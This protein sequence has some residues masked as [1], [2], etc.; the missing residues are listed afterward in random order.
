MDAKSLREKMK[1]KARRLAGEKNEKVDA[2]TWT[3]GDDLDAGTKVGA[4]P[5]SKRA[6]KGGGGIKGK[7][8]VKHAGRVARK[9]GGKVADE[10]A[11]TNVKD[12]NEDREGKKHTGGWKKGGEVKKAD[13]G[14]VDAVKAAMAAKMLMNKAKSKKRDKDGDKDDAF[15]RGGRASG[16]SAPT[17]GSVDNETMATS[18]ISGP[19]D[20]GGPKVKP[21]LGKDADANEEGNENAALKFK[22]GGRAARATGGNVGK[23]KTNINIVIAPQTAEKPQ[24]PVPVAG[25][26][27]ML[28]KPP[29]PPMGAPPMGAGPS[30]APGGMPQLPPHMA[31]GPGPMPPGMPPM[32]MPRKSGGRAI[33]ME[34]GAGSGE[35]RLEKVRKYGKNA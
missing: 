23:G 7:A 2:S 18:S 25:P 26:P 27:P 28:P 17:G 30:G 9:S 22:K 20:K 16:G 15:K 14:E 33:K 4:R 34:N 19:A 5:I 11:N 3:P 29:M 12:A 10:I 32:P 8:A 31:G 24:M 6:Y 13:G 1:E 21:L 35:G